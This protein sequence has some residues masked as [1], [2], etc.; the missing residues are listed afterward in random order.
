MEDELIKRIESLESWVR[1]MLSSIPSLR[2][3]LESFDRDIN[4]FNMSESL[5]KEE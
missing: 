5:T 3:N 1:F 2:D 4:I